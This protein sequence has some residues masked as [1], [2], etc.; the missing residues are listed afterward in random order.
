MRTTPFIHTSS[1]H[2]SYSNSSSHITYDYI[3]PSVIPY[4][5]SVR[6]PYGKNDNMFTNEESSDV[7]S[8]YQDLMPS[9]ASS[10]LTR[11]LLTPVIGSS[12]SLSSWEDDYDSEHLRNFVSLLLQ[13][14]A[15]SLRQNEKVYYAPGRVTTTRILTEF[16]VRALPGS[17][18]RVVRVNN[19]GGD[20]NTQ[21]VVTDRLIT[22]IP[23]HPDVLTMHA[24]YHY[25]IF[26]WSPPH[27]KSSCGWRQ[28]VC[29]DRPVIQRTKDIKDTDGN[30]VWSHNEIQ[31]FRP[32]I[33]MSNVWTAW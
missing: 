12:S 31:S 24:G 28:L 1:S 6:P 30:V 19:S 8:V 2:K 4:P 23:V 33:P 21:H 26:I 15:S 22:H 20:I 32:Y 18:I 27:S 5:V 25:Y 17:N 29:H 13:K 9:S 11:I 14:N 16:R 7:V 3:H 10:A